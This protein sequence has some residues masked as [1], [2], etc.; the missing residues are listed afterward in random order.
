MGPQPTCD[1]FQAAEYDGTTLF[2]YLVIKGQASVTDGGAIE[3]MDHLAQWYIGPGSTYPAR[4][5]PSGWT[6]RVT[7]DTIYG[8][9]PWNPRWVEMDRASRTG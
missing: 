6:F 8:Q 2:P 4:D 7:I 9:G 3:V 1:E 5:M